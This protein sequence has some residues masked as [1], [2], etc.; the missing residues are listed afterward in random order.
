MSEYQFI[1]VF[2]VQVVCI[3]AAW[4]CDQFP[5]DQDEAAIRA[6]LQKSRPRAGKILG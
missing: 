4:V 6:V 1:H 5:G 2:I 3:V